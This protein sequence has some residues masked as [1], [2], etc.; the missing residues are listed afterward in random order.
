M[1]RVLEKLLKGRPA[2]NP[3]AA[4]IEAAFHLISESFKSGGKLLLCGNGGSAADCEH[5]AGELMK[6]FLLKRPLPEARRRAFHALGEQGAFLGEKLQGALPCIPLTGCAALSTAFAN[7]VDPLLV[8]A[9]Q[10]YGYGRP[11]DV[12]MALSTSG[13]ADNVRAAVYTA[14]ALGLK[15]IGL[16]GEDGGALYKLCDVTIRVP[17]SETYLVQEL[18]LPVYHGLCAMLEDAFFGA[19]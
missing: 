14:K 9:Q 1:N 8:F 4:D 7:D 19:A 10:V 17:E 16:T 3:C 18:H 13:N 11:G 12:L 5:I 2:L 15:T 6:G